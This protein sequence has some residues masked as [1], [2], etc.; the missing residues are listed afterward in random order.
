M[1]TECFLVTTVYTRVVLYKKT[2]KDVKK[3]QFNRNALF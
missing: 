1:F 3:T 2:L